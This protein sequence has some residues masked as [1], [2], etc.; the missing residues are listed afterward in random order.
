YSSEGKVRPNTVQNCLT[1]PAITLNKKHSEK[2]I[3][4]VLGTPPFCIQYSSAAAELSR[5]PTDWEN[6]QSRFGK[7]LEVQHDCGNGAGVKGGGG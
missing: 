6:Y 3:Q 4:A 1:A 2:H 5:Y 7:G